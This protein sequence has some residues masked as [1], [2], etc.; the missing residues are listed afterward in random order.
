[1]KFGENRETQNNKNYRYYKSTFQELLDMV[2][3]KG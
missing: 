1:M 2:L 3:E